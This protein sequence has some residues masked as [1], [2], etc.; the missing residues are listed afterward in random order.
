[1]AKHEPVL[2]MVQL[3]QCLALLEL[4]PF[5]DDGKSVHQRL[6]WLAQAQAALAALYCALSPVWSALAQRVLLEEAPPEATKMTFGSLTE[7]QEALSGAVEDVAES[8]RMC[9]KTET[10]PCALVDGQNQTVLCKVA[11]LRAMGELLCAQSEWKE[12]R[13]GHMGMHH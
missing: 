5:P 7:F 11:Y 6:H 9:T 4:A 1:M 12:P 13:S 10:P 2:D 8:L 3:R